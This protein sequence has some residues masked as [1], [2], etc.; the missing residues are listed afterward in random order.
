MEVNPTVLIVGAGIGGLFL[1]NLLQHAG[2]DFEIFERSAQV[3]PLGSAMVAGP[4]I[5][6]VFSQLG[7][8]KQMEK[9]SK[10]LKCLNVYNGSLDKLGTVEANTK[11]RAGYYSL[12]FARK[13]L[14]ALLLSQIPPHKIHLSKKILSMQELEDGVAIH[15]SDKS[16]Y[17]GDILVGAD[18]AYSGVRQSLYRQ[19][20]AAKL[21]PKNDEE[22]LAM[23]YTCLVGTTE[24][25]DPVE[26]PFLGDDFAHF[27]IVLAKNSSESVACFTIP[28]NKICWLYTVQLSANSP[29]ERFSNSEWGPEATQAMCEKIRHIKAPFGRTMGELI[30]VTP[31]DSLSKVMLEEKLFQTWYHGRTVLIGDACH[32][33]LPS[34]GQGAINAMQDATILANCINDIKRLD[35]ESISAHLKDYQDQR[36]QFAKI[37]FE[38][39]K[40]FA[41]IMGGQ[42]WSEA[43]IRK[44]VLAYMPKSLNRRRQDKTCAYQPQAN[45]LKL[46][47]ER[48]EIETL[49]QVP[50]K[51]YSFD[52]NS[53]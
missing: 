48:G 26:F 6:P 5:L 53:V 22:D 23:R 47:P 32:K 16:R 34:A 31:K 4:N 30:D 1:A 20:A 50:S 25:L 2:I 17:V 9:I 12:V 43:L 19:L 11:E 39:S 21:L 49:P 37:Q 24:S 35:R 15:C 42:T 36:Y 7:L 40:R 27:E 28:D 41:V 3:K 14:Y 10:P 51:R 38:T 52:A 33:M 8:L 18:G 13:N 44:V 46:A 45:F 29:D